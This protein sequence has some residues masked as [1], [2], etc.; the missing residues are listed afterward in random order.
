MKQKLMQVMMERDEEKPLSG[1][2][3]LDDAYLGGERSGKPGRGAANNPPFLL[4]P[5]SLLPSHNDT[6]M[7]EYTIP[8]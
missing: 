5:A 6:S 3:E 2:V 4:N 1:F 7:I 8:H